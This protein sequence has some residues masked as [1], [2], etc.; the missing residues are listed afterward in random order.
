MKILLDE[1]LPRR[2]KYSFSIHDCLTVP[3]AGFSG[4]KNGELLRRATG[5]GF[6]VPITADRNLSYQQD[7]TRFQIAI[8][9]LRSK[10]NRLEDLR[11]L[12]PSILASLPNA[13]PGQVILI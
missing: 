11:E 5:A 7:A 13:E 4:L 10:T 6:T 2:L 3:D 12:V 1:C 9:V 8:I